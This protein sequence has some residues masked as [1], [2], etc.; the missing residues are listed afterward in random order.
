M[1]ANRALALQARTILC[2]T[3]GTAPPAPDDMI[4]SLAA[5]VL[6]PAVGER[7]PGFIDPFSRLLRE[8][9]NIQVPVFIWPDWPTRDL[10]ISAAPYNRLE[11]YLVLSEAL[12]V[13]LAAAA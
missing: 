6:P 4:G 11:D 3:V 9:W 8:K 12:T 13:E 2:E 5:V 7:P 1:A 10:R